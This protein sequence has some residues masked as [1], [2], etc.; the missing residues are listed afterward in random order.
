MH[1]DAF[2]GHVVIVTGASA[3]IGKALA[4]LLA[5]QGAK[6]A[7]FE[8][9][10]R[11]HCGG[12]QHGWQSSH[13]LQ[14]TLHCQKYALHGFFDALRMEE[15]RSGVSATVICLWW[16]VTEFHEAQLD[17]N[18]LPYGPRGRANY[19]RR[20]MSADRCAEI[21]LHAVYKCRGEVLLGARI[22]VSSSL[23]SSGE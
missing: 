15:S 21:T 19:S 12:L 8:T 1:A 13:S 10:P 9:D 11:P 7:I 17:K 5:R 3:G 20:R 14:Y 16:V 6:V 2:R 23:V 18:G 22:L 4:L